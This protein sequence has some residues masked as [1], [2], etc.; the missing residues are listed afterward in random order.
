MSA[1]WSD[2]LNRLINSGG[3]TKKKPLSRALIVKEAKEPRK[4]VKKIAE[5]DSKRVKP[6]LQDR[7]YE[8]MLQSIATKGVVQLFNTLT[9]LEED[10]PPVKQSKMSDPGPSTSV[11][12]KWGDLTVED[13]EEDDAI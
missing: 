8:R 5:F 13:D 11:L 10:E 9:E 6:S 12:D 4:I 7:E 3:K 1:G 2:V